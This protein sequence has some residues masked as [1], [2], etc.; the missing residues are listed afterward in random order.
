MKTY[1]IEFSEGAREDLAELANLIATASFIERAERYIG[2]LVRECRSLSVAPHRGTRLQELRPNMRLIAYKHTVNIVFRI[3]EA[4]D[5]V[6][7]L[8]FAYK[9]RSLEHILNRDE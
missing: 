2:K 1:R 3:E 8:G 4:I 5:T 9:G 7:I 6:V